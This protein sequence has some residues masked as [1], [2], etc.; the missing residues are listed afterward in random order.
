MDFLSSI[1]LDYICA[2]VIVIALLASKIWLLPYLKT[3]GINQEYYN[4]IQEA[5]LLGGY[6]FRSEKV[7]KILSIAIRIVSTLEVL[8]SMD[9]TQKHTEAVGELAEKL[10]KE[11]N[12]TFNKDTL[13]RL[14]RLAVAFMGEGQK[15]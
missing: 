7:T 4:L 1:N 11:L 5:L 2:V 6:A 15:K 13:D 3:K 12:M 8:D 9:S 14:V 10:L